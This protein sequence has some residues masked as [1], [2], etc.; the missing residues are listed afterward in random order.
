LASDSSGVAA[1][2]EQLRHVRFTEHNVLTY[3]DIHSFRQVY[4][5]FAKEKLEANEAVAILPY[6]DTIYNIKHFLGEL[7]IDVLK[8]EIEGGLLILDSLKTF[9]GNE[10]NLPS[11]LAAFEGAARLLSNRTGISVIID[12]GA[13]FHFDENEVSR[14]VNFEASVPT[15]HDLKCKSLLCC[16]HQKD[17]KKI[18]KAQQDM[19]FEKHHRRIILS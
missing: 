11:V 14:L 6:Y 2:L 15:M 16:Y 4:S 13:F 10:I 7:E 12:M 5:R 19:I 8:Q 17:L 9:Y 1:M 18:P 3:P